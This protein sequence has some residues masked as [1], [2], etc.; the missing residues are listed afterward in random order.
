MAKQ[1]KTER[2]YVKVVS[3]F[4]STGYMLP[5]SI[6]WADGR[7]FPIEKVRD[8]RPA[9]TADN[10]FSGD[11]FTVLIQGQEKHLFF[12]HIAPPFH[13]APRQM[14]CG[15]DDAVNYHFLERRR[16]IQCSLLI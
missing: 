8:F 14:V 5:T 1:Q 3:E 12:E 4:D 15:E 13:R 7:T 6:T 16:F 10:G 11:C 2:V 9:G